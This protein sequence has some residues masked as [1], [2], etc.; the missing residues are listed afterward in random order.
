[1][2]RVVVLTSTAP[3]HRYFAAVMARAFDVLAVLVQPKTGYYVDQAERSE[4]I[5]AHLARNSEAEVAEFGDPGVPVES[6]LVPD[7]NSPAVIEP[8]KTADLVLLFGTAILRA[9]WLEAFPQRIINLHLGLSPFY[10]GSATLF[11]PFVEGEL[12]CV[13][14]TIHLAAARVDAG[15][16]LRRVRARAQVGDSYY[17][18]TNR[19]I[20]EA[21]EAVPDTVHS[22]KEGSL[23]PQPQGGVATRAYRK[24]D[25]DEAAL[26]RAL[27]FV[28]DGITQPMIEEAERRTR[29]AFSQ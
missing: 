18:L 6:T 28:G 12:A 14:A 8:I 25:F 26:A 20:R 5:R 27:A 22:Y 3:R 7:I 21:I 23:T 11:W 15:D 4:A 13:G 1:M 9:P 16:I 29:C 10:R 17:S 2:T 24:A 19:T